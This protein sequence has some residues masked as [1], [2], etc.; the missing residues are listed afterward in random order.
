MDAAWTTEHTE[1]ILAWRLWRIQRVET[2]EGDE[3]LR[4]AAAG[5]LGIPRFWRPREPNRA[6]CSSHRTQHEAPWPACRCGIYGFRAQEA[7]ERA[8]RRYARG[9][10][11]DW[12]IGRV[13]LWG[14][15]V[16]CKHGWRAEYAYPYDVTLLGGDPEAVRELRDLY[17]V[18][19]SLAD[20]AL[21]ERAAR[22][23]RAARKRE[24]GAYDDWMRAWQDATAAKLAPPEGELRTVE[25]VIELRVQASAR[26][27]LKRVSVDR[28]RWDVRG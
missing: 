6:V 14:R 9:D 26:G 5:R 24:R 22:R 7:A 19:V 27:A 3:P 1:P 28:R 12:A 20:R 4:L 18:D 16:E 10:V 21:A 17:A 25:S 11:S 13:S 8:L 15:I 23:P 2:L